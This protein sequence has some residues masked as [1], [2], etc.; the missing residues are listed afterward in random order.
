MD[1]YKD[2]TDRKYPHQGSGIGKKTPKKKKKKNKNKKD[3]G[4]SLKSVTSHP[5]AKGIGNSLIAG[6]GGSAI[7]AYTGKYSLMTG[8]AINVLGQYTDEYSEWFT[9][10]GS[11]TIGYGFANIGKDKTDPEHQTAEGRLN[12]LK[13][14]YLLLLQKELKELKEKSNNTATETPP[15]EP[16]LEGTSPDTKE[17]EHLQQEV[18][19]ANQVFE[20]IEASLQEIADQSQHPFPDESEEEL[21][22]DHPPSEDEDIDEDDIHLDL[23]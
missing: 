5:I 17:D 20:E 23:I 19:Q 4:F 21:Q 8:L 10:L 12:Q 7:A 6:I 18:Q 9:A 3:K 2:K 22:E 13:N 11:G 16:S 14:N 1:D 15:V